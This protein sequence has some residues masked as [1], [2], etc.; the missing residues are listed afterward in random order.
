MNNTIGIFY[1]LPCGRI[2]RTFGFNGPEKT[3]SY[4][5]DDGE[6]DRAATDAEFQTWTPQLELK[7][8]PN[9]RDPRLPAV[10]DLFWDIKYESQLRQ[11]LKTGHADIE[12]IRERMR[13]YDISV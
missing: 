11:L 5:F 1:K 7:D 12:D 9:A 8:F 2:A 3:I 10:F 13:D 6:G 4:Y